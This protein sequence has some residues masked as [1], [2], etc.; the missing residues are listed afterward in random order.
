MTEEPVSV[1]FIDRLW[2]H[3][4]SL[5]EQVASQSRLLQ[6]LRD[7]KVPFI[8]SLDDNLLDLNI[9]AGERPW[10]DMRQRMICRRFIREAACVMV[11]TSY[12]AERIAGL[13]KKVAYFPNQIDERLFDVGRDNDSVVLESTKTFGY[14]GTFTHFDDLIS[15]SQ[16]LRSFLVQNPDSKFEVVGIGDPEL[17]KTLLPLDNVFIKSVPQE[18][19]DYPQFAK[20]MASNLKWDFA[21]A[22]LRRSTFNDCKSDIKFLDYAA[23][24]IPGIFSNVPAY[25]STVRHEVNGLIVDESLE[26]WEH[27]INQLGN[28]GHL[29]KKLGINAKAEVLQTRSLASHASRWADL[30]REIAE[31]VKG[32]E[33]RTSKKDPLQ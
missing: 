9:N 10:P 31:S 18:A 13:A 8:Y 27:A 3:D 26:N 29:V 1:V 23:C 2:R 12:L 15:I 14:M 16:P 25:S 28:D 6:E 17:I 32:T 19:V 7:R 33:K 20:W 21:L 11:S 30:A 24:G 22:P 5:E 4:I